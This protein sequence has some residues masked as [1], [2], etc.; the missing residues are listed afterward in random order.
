MFRRR[1][2]RC[3]SS[4][5]F[6]SFDGRFRGEEVVHDEERRSLKFEAA[7]VWPSL[8]LHDVFA[9]T[10]F[11]Y[12]EMESRASRC[13]RKAKVCVTG[14]GSGEEEE[15]GDAQ[16]AGHGGVVAEFIGAAFL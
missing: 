9:E 13:A 2:W 11:L 8:R 1:G 3:L 14:F 12:A 6:H 16:R 7:A 10:V 4:I 15:V 5:C